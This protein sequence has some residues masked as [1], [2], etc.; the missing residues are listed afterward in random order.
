MKQESSIF[1]QVFWLKFWGLLIVLLPVEVFGLDSTGWVQAVSRFVVGGMVGLG[2][3]HVLMRSELKLAVRRAEKAR[4]EYELAAATLRV[5]GE[6]A[7]HVHEIKA[8]RA[9]ET[10]GLS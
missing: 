6:I 4:L 10:G 2:I 1:S 5:R 8:G 7:I 3:V 9:Y